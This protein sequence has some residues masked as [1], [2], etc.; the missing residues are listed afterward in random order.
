[1]LPHT[2]L[3]CAE[4]SAKSQQC[5]T[6]QDLH[7]GLASRLRPPVLKLKLMR[8]NMGMQ[9]GRRV[10]SSRSCSSSARSRQPCSARLRRSSAARC[11]FLQL[12]L[13][14]LLC[15]ACAL[16]CGATCAQAALVNSATPAE[17]VAQSCVLAHAGCSAGP[18]EA[19]AR[20]PGRLDRRRGRVNSLCCPPGAAPMLTNCDKAAVQVLR[21]QHPV[22]SHTETLTPPAGWRRSRGRDDSVVLFA[23]RLLCAVVF[24]AAGQTCHLER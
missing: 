13:H 22:A 12:Q 15:T 7:C 14:L 1:M 5:K 9:Q 10:R 19:Q 21:C 6:D 16:C 11:R 18:G 20:L 2:E 8:R 4:H 3:L 23:T 17:S 24:S